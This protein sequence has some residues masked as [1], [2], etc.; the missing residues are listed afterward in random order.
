[1]KK[2]ILTGIAG[3][4]VLSVVFAGGM[5][6][7][8]WMNYNSTSLETADS[9]LDRI[10]E[11]FDELHNEKITV[12][13]ALAELE[14][15]NPKGLVDKI[16]SL[17]KSLGEK[18]QIIANH[19]SELEQLKQTNAQLSTDL[20]QAKQAKTDAENALAG[21]QEELNNKQ[22]E[23]EAKQAEI[24]EKNQAYDQLQQQR[25]AIAA[26]RDNYK[27]QVDE[28][29]N[30]VKHLEA[31]LEK[32]NNASASHSQKTSEALEQAESYK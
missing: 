21:K 19:V 15:L 2:R 30:Y 28:N 16:K 23:I 20:A 31:E 6:A 13:Q 17:E 22:A 3:L 1:M 24:N 9:D 18:D 8:S 25:D 5:M 27:A 26:E 29:N 10:M 11:L 32:A 7:N 12:E 4:L 14:E